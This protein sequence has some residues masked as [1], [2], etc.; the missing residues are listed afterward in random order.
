MAHTREKRW[1]HRLFLTVATVILTAS[2]VYLI[3]GASDPDYYWGRVAAAPTTR[4]GVEPGDR[5]LLHRDRE[6]RIGR[7]TLIYRGRDRREV[8]LDV[9]I[10]ELDPFYA[11][12]HTFSPDRFHR[13]I[14]LAGL[15]LL[16]MSANR[17]ILRVRRLN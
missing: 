15:D 10:P 16:P 11:Y 6:T 13:V 2:T 3:R 4:R 17:N 5:V 9:V 7:A 1:P 14:R 8:R 12:H